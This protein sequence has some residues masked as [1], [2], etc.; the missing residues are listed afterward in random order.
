M[1]GDGSIYRFGPFELDSSRR[2]LVRGADRISISIRGLDVLLVLVANAGELVSKETLSN[3]R[4]L[5]LP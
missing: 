5:A 3:A 4:G 1:R 2:T